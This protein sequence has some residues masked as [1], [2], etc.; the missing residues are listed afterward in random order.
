MVAIGLLSAKGSPG[1]TTTA[2]ALS[3]VWADVVPGRRVLVAE[4]DVAGGDI[5]TGFLAGNL[6]SARG[7][8]ALALSRGLEPVDAVWEQLLALDETG[9]RLLLPGIVDH[10]Q[11]TNAT[12]A[13]RLLLAALPELASQEPPVDVLADL[14][15]LHTNGEPRELWAGLDRIV[16]VTRSSLAAVAAAQAAAVEMR[17]EY[18]GERLRC[19]V[20]DEGRPYSATEIA[21]AV[22]L[23]LAGSV[24]LDHRVAGRPDRA[25]RGSALHRACRLLATSLLDDLPTSV[26]GATRV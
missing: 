2:L 3:A 19:L 4:C 18:S 8:L 11:A 20:I 12:A 21:R 7:M 26:A 13:W 9:D 15:R 23:P 17:E 1:C 14:G 22:Q 25:L 16:L 10:R 6:D 5:A 24:P